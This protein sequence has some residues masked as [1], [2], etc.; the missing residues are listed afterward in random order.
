MACDDAKGVAKNYTNPSWPCA[1]EATAGPGS[2]ICWKRCP[3]YQ[4]WDLAEQICVE[5]DPTWNEN[6]DLAMARARCGDHYHVPAYL[7][8]VSLLENCE[9]VEDPDAG[10]TDGGAADGGAG[11]AGADAGEQD[12][13]TESMV[14]YECEGCHQSVICADMFPDGAHY[15]VYWSENRCP[16]DGDPVDDPTEWRGR[17]VM[18]FESGQTLCIRSDDEISALCVHASPDPDPPLYF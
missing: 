14:T 17:K 9:V 16:R 10:P 18:D 4:Q 15:A 7:E 2:E 11:D 12:A 3:A 6:S 5:H 13:G 8:L 1:P